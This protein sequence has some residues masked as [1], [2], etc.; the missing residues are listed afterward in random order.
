MNHYRIIDVSLSEIF[1]VIYVELFVVVSY[2]KNKIF[3]TFVIYVVYRKFLWYDLTL[4]CGTVA[5]ISSIT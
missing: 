5:V 2:V 3:I 4:C 1:S